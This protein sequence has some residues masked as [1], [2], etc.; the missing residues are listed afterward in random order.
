MS[1]K[2][3]R[4]HNAGPT[5]SDWFPSLEPGGNIVQTIKDNDNQVNI[6]PTSIPSPFARMDLVRSAFHFVNV[7]GIDGNT[8]HH[9]LVSDALDIG[10]ILFNYDINS[11]DLELIAWNKWDQLNT[12]KASTH[13]EHK[14]LAETLELFISQDI[15]FNFDKVD[16]FYILKYNH[17]VIGGVS[18]TT[19]FFAAPYNDSK[20]DNDKLHVDIRFGNDIMLDDHYLP[21]YQ[22]E[23]KY[24]KYMYALSKKD[25]FARTFKELYQYIDLTVKKLSKENK[26][27]F[28]VLNTLDVN[29]YF[30]G[31]QYL[32]IRGN[33]GDTV[34]ALSDLPLYKYSANPESIQSDFAI[35]SPKQIEVNGKLLSPLVL[36]VERFNFELTYTVEK[37]N[38]ATPAP[39]RD[40][41]PI[42]LRRL[43]HVR[44]QYPY[45]TQA[46]FLEDHLIKVPY[47][48]NSNKF[49]TLG[50]NYLLPI[51]PTFFEY[52]TK[53]ELTSQKLIEIIE[54]KQSVEVRLHIPITG[55]RGVN[56]ITYS[57]I[58]K[59]PSTV[60]NIGGMSGLGEHDGILVDADL[61]LAITPLVKGDFSHKD[62]RIGIVNGMPSRNVDLQLYDSN[63]FRVDAKFNNTRLNKG[64]SS[65]YYVVQD[66]F[67][68]V[69]LQVDASMHG[70]LIPEFKKYESGN[71]QFSFAID[72]GTS[73]THIEYKKQNERDSRPFKVE[74][75]E[76]QI[77][78]SFDP[79]EK[80][81]LVRQFYFQFSH[82]LLPETI[83]DGSND[84]K[85][86]MRTVVLY[87]K[88][89][90]V[91][92]GTY[93]Y[94]HYNI[95]FDFEKSQIQPHLNH[96]TNIKWSNYNDNENRKQLEHYIEHILIL[97]RNKVLLNDGNL[98]ETKIT[99][100]YP[101]SM[102]ENKINALGQVWRG[103]VQEIFGFRVVEAMN[104]LPESLA[105]FYFYNNE[106][107]VTAHSLPVASLDIGGGTADLV[108]YKEDRPQL[109]TSFKFAGNAIF[110]DGYG[111]SMA[112]NGFLK[113]HLDKYRELVKSN[114]DNLYNVL[115]QLSVSRNSEDIIN[116]LF[117][118]TNNKT[119]TQNNV[120]I[121]FATEL[122]NDQD[123]KLVFLLYYSAVFYHMSKVMHAAGFD[124]P[125]ILL[126]SGS[127]SKTAFI[128]DNTS[129]QTN[130][131]LLFN[132]IFEKVSGEQSKVKT[133][134]KIEPNPKEITAKGGLYTSAYD[135]ISLEDL[136]VVSLGSTLEIGLLRPYDTSS[137]ALKYSYRDLSKS[138]EHVQGVVD[139]VLHFLELFLELHKEI[140]FK[141]KFD[142]SQTSLNVI[143]EVIENGDHDLM[144]YLMRGLGEKQKELDSDD[145]TAVEETLFFYPLVGL[146]NKLA[147]DSI[148]GK[149]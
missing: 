145:V 120:K 130:L 123:L 49:Y 122:A 60:T 41:T 140:N 103:K 115:E 16:N 52:F 84:Y 55:S 51:K 28:N 70:F 95:A 1:K 67:D 73:N 7:N 129:N 33:A 20:P 86:P 56:K 40:D 2:V 12:L 91:N 75:E 96:K 23:P 74:K 148:D 124:K 100:F 141:N 17:H 24:I 54:Q 93:T 6:L 149:A 127:G 112:T 45:L 46:D 139:E 44:D 11:D 85:L 36:P 37:W 71:N 82:E 77:A 133:E 137:N 79:N 78:Y 53:E 101:S 31:L 106:A 87:N 42:E 119:L 5:E 94:N 39:R 66:N 18:P 68:Y 138:D 22:R 116:F 38:P 4:I 118:L 110:G 125:S 9:K 43:P 83:N 104:S 107:G 48:L 69:Q 62:Y 65:Q 126:L 97:L 134:I 19:L 114:S 14:A 8:Y 13:P 58:Y 61:A 144:N 34:H 50:K 29:D 92:H 21:L 108:V 59:R 47:Q 76:S 88:N 147:K 146:L 89:V 32:H 135:G 113:K 15:Q 136:T 142:V 128:A 131:S 80:S 143:D 98:E 111:G 121:D 81:A 10:Q 102:G 117:S 26:D 105:P 63:G 99:W 25:N 35:A 57:K 72:F 30:S 64:A 109:L 132:K 3:F 27:L 90:N